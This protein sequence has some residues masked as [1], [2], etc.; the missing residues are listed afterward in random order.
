MLFFREHEPGI[1]GYLWR[2][3]G[4]RQL[5]SDLS[6]ETFLRAWHSFAKVRG[7]ENQ[8][9]WLLHVATNLALNS[10]RRRTT[11]IGA[12]LRWTRPQSLARVTMPGR[13]RSEMPCTMCYSLRP[14]TSRQRWC[15]GRW[16][17]SPVPRLHGGHRA[18]SRVPHGCSCR[19][20][21][22]S[23]AGATGVRRRS[24]EYADRAGRRPWNSRPRPSP[25]GATAPSHRLRG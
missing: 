15:Y 2:I 23:S 25:H 12:L 20:P 9:T 18:G 10:R 6:Q 14:Y 11:W 3:T 7:Y 5:A 19:V 16:R 22:S 1:Y 21:A 17:V 4:D 13:S 8:A 24:N